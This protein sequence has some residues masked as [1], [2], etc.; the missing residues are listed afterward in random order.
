M[1]KKIFEI[2]NRVWKREKEQNEEKEFS[3]H[4]SERLNT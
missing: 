2:K 3:F 1:A 4:E